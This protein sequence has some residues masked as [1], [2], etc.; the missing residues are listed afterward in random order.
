M[1]V[2]VG[3]IRSVTRSFNSTG[4]SGS[5][6][7][8]FNMANSYQIRLDLGIQKQPKRPLFIGEIQRTS[9]ICAFRALILSLGAA[10]FIVE[11]AS[12]ECK[13][14]RGGLEVSLCSLGQTAI[15]PRRARTQNPSFR[16]H[17][18]GTGGS[19]LDRDVSPVSLPGRHCGRF[20]VHEYQAQ[21]PHSHHCSSQSS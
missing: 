19:F 4:S 21:C 9:P 8:S 1:K 5:D 2:G 17:R 3:R 20:P 16:T 11:C 10:M 6:L 15:G 13:F 14:A 12:L 18:K 7:R